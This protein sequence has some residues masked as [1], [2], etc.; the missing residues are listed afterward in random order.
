MAH[1]LP[2]PPREAPALAHELIAILAAL[3]T[4]GP[5]RD[6][7]DHREFAFIQAARALGGTWDQIAGALGHGNAEQRYEDL[8]ERFAPPDLDNP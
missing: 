1:I 3:K 4:I 2:G 7:L 8:R 5:Q 6:S